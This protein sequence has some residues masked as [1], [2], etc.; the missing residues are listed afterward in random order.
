MSMALRYG[1]ELQGGKAARAIEYLMAGDNS[2]CSSS[3]GGNTRTY[4]GLLVHGTTL[5]LAGL[6][7][8]VDGVRISAQQYRNTTGDEGLEHLFAFSLYP[9]S[10]TFM[11]GAVPIRK[12]ITFSSGVTITYT[13]TGEATLTIRPLITERPVGRVVRAYRPVYE[14]DTWGVRWGGAVLE[15]DLPFTQDPVSYWNIL[16]EREEERGYDAVEDLFSPGYFSGTVRDGSVSLRC[17]LGGQAPRKTVLP[18]YPESLPGMLDYAAEAFCRGDEILAGYPW[19]RESWG[20]DTAISV[21]GLLIERD[22][23]EMAQAVL[24]RIAAKMEN[25]VIPN[26]FPD[27]YRSSDASLWFIRA[28]GRYRSR[29]GDDPFIA[30]M[31]PVVAEI[32]ARYPFSGVAALDGSLIRVVPQS[33]WMDTVHTPRDGKPVEINALWIHALSEAEAMGIDPPVSPDSARDAFRAFWNPEKNCLYDRID[34]VDAAVR[35]NQVVAL[36]L[37]LVEPEQAASA[38]RTVTRELLTPYGLRSLSPHEQ[39]YR[40]RFS[41]DESYHNGCVWPWLTGQ[42]VEGLIRIGKDPKAIAPLLD[43]ILSH[44]RE[45]GAGYIS[46]IF[47]GDP[48]FSPRGCIAQAWSVAEI[49][50]A[51]RMVSQSNRNKL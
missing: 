18:S 6:D 12:I 3:P 21:P 14:A 10:W 31:R 5:C 30:G 33:T 48:P 42:Y 50:H 25:G 26:R 7:E 39:A 8:Y 16:Y 32:L 24:R 34:P 35:P 37:G 17:F 29:W 11:A 22:K 40:G 20:R 9:P 36:A 49:L 23:K 1:R 44:I 2:Y 45:A 4:H 27:N 13:I 38:L 51:C 47:D 19:F 41:G 28:L 46:E 43:P 15:G